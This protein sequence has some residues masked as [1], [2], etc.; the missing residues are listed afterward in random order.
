[1]QHGTGREFVRDI[2]ENVAAVLDR[3]Q[4]KS[5]RS[6]ADL[7]AAL[8]G[9]IEALNAPASLDER[10]LYGPDYGAHEYGFAAEMYNGPVGSIRDTRP[11]G[12]GR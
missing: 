7:R 12:L 6:Y 9:A 10:G 4:L 5:G 2:I 8:R 11:E 3:E 1:M